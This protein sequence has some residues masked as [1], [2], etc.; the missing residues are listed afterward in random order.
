MPDIPESAAKVTAEEFRAL[1]KVAGLTVSEDRAPLVLDELNSQLAFSRT[2]DR[3]L[4]GAKE[5][6]FAP[7]DP[8]FPKIDLE[9]EAE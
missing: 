9:E 3:V 7:F 4:E 8:T 6:D 1:L 5:S 2:L